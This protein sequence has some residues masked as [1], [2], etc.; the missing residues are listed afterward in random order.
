VIKLLFILAFQVGLKILHHKPKLKN[1]ALTTESAKDSHDLMRHQ[2]L[3]KSITGLSLNIKRNN[4]LRTRLKN[5][6]LITALVIDSQDLKNLQRP[7]K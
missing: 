7:L 6:L 5:H 3:P 2:K 4:Y 1:Q